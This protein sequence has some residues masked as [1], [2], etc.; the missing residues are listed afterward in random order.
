MLV[1][2]M[3]LA[4]GIALLMGMPGIPYAFW[5]LRKL[6][7]S[8]FDKLMIG[9]TIGWVGVPL[10][11][12]LESILGIDYSSPWI[13]VNWVAALVPGL[14]L[15]HKEGMLSAKAISSAKDSL[16]KAAADPLGAVSSRSAGIF[17]FLLIAAAVI[18]RLSSAGGL[19]F[20]LDP[21]FYLDGVRQVIY[22][23][24]NFFDDQ[25]AWYPFTPSNHVGNPLF[26]YLLAPWFSIY[27]GGAPYSPYVLSAVSSVYAP[28]AGG[29]VVYFMYLLFREMFDRRAGI[30]AAGLSAFLP[31]FMIKFQGGDSQIVPYSIFALV[32]FL[33]MLYSALRRRSMELTAL[34]GLAY[35]A[36]ILGSNIEILIVFCLA[37]F[38]FAL[39]LRHVLSPDDDSR[40]VNR[41]VIALLAMMFA[42]QVVNL[43]YPEYVYVA[44]ELKGWAVSLA[45]NFLSIAAAFAIPLAVD[46]AFE[47]YSPSTD[48]RLRAA[49]CVAAV[50][51]AGLAVLQLSLFSDLVSLYRYWGSYS[52]PLTKTIAEQAPGSPT[53]D[54]VF[55]FVAMNF[56]GTNPV[57]L[58]LA[59]LNLIP[60]LIFN[61]FFNLIASVVNIALG[62]AGNFPIIERADSA[63]TLFF[64]LGIGLLSYGVL[65]PLIRRKYIPLYP[66]M[67]LA[68]V[69]PMTFMGL[70]KEKLITY[71]GVTIIFSATAAFAECEERISSF[72]GRRKAE[73]E[74]EGKGRKRKAEKVTIV[75]PSALTF[76]NFAWL[77]AIALISL[78]FGFP[79]APAAAYGAPVL[80]S[81]PTPTFQQDPQASLPLF[82]GICQTYH[83]PLSCAVSSNYTSFLDDPASFYDQSL[84]V[85]SLLGDPSGQVSGSA[86]IAISYRCSFISQ[87]WISAM[88]WIHADVPQG[89]RVISWWDYGHW[90]NY[91]GQSYTVLRN[92][93]AN[94][95]MIG[96]TA[97]AYLDTDA[98]GLRSTMNAFHS[99]YALMDI[100]IL[101]G[102]SRDSMS[103]GGK[104]GALNYLACAYAN[105]TDVTHDPGGS[106]CEADHLW[107]SI[108]IPTAPQACGLTSGGNQSGYVA[109]RIRFASNGTSLVPS[110]DPAY[111]AFVGKLEDGRQALITYDLDSR[112]ASGSLALHPAIWVPEGRSAQYIQFAAIYDH[113]QLWKDANGTLIDS[114]PYRTTAFYNSTLYQGFM[115]GSIDGYDLVYDTPQVRIFRMKDQYYT[116]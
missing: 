14:Y 111:C 94:Q 45:E 52:T 54:G 115:L 51:I 56:D 34:A 48:R 60:T 75:L 32:F 92:E 93:H 47:R 6:E 16:K 24:R 107:E 104:Y 31:F 70:E 50:V 106:Q 88:Q 96:Q 68:F 20:E 86:G 30:L 62:G 79:L 109:Y 90:I 83:D 63:L 74:T 113:E 13:A 57:S 73:P 10:I 81:A 18:V 55:G 15:L 42:V 114:Y 25:T 100:E 7:F 43:L 26:K 9:Y 102:G 98:A 110:L 108:V 27:N 72:L 53:Y 84:C 3:W 22:Q 101:G 78:E 85:R 36:L 38:T 116:G 105:Q 5:L 4:L 66:L 44:S 71:L 23:G 89:D 11:F 46:R 103:F 80:F 29:L 35:A 76:G 21:Y 2:D 8:A 59:V 99:R 37:A 97:Y 61:L 77:V 58:A 17:L 49:A 33:S 82:S 40:E 95:T 39:S 19:L 112:D 69:L 67:L 41:L 28:L 1:L 64:F 91:L 12:L 65:A 87:Y